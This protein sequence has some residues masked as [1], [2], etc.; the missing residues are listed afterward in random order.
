M[1]TQSLYILWVAAFALFA[2][3]VVAV[4]LVIICKKRQR[5]KQIQ[6][7]QS[8]SI[9]NSRHGLAS[10]NN[11]AIVNDTTTNRFSIVEVLPP[12]YNVSNA[13]VNDS[14]SPPDSPFQRSHTV[15]LATLPPSP[16]PC[17]FVPSQQFRGS[18]RSRINTFTTSQMHQPSIG[19]RFGSASSATTLFMLSTTASTHPLPTEPPPSYEE[20]M[21][22]RSFSFRR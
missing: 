8:Q 9:V 11:S 21:R 4:L 7:I 22:A 15:A 3:T 17:L 5:Q 19:Q 16:K 14:S 13:S 20:S 12:S 2:W 10:L 1:E 18:Q 6:Q